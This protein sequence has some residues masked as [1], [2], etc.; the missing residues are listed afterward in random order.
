MRNVTGF[1]VVLKKTSLLCNIDTPKNPK[2][3]SGGNTW[4][5]FTN[6]TDADLFMKHPF[7]KMYYE[8]AKVCITVV[9]KLKK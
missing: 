4:H 6:R 1:A 8:I 5:I 9:R 3:L 7:A 2:M